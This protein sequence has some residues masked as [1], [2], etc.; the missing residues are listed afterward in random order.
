MDT[1]DPKTLALSLETRLARL[2][3]YCCPQTGAI[4]PPLHASA[5]FARDTAYEKIG[6]RGYAR[7]ENPTYDVLENLLASLDGAAEARVF[8]T[9]MAAVAGLF[10]A[11]RPGDHT[12]VSKTQYFGTPKWLRDWAVPWGLEIDLVDTTDL[13]AVAAAL[14]PGQTKLVY[15]ETPANPTW[16][17]TDIRGC[18]DLAHGIGARLAVDTTAARPVLCQPIAHGA[19]LVVQSAT[20]WLNGHSDVLAGVLSTARTDGFWEEIVRN[21]YL[22]GA[23]LGSFEAWLLTRGLRTLFLRVRH[24]SQSALMIARRL[25]PHPGLAAV[26]YPGLASDPGHEVATRQMTGGF[27]GLLSLRVKGGAEAALEV[28]KR[29]RVFLRATSIGHIESLIEHRATIEGADSDTPPDLLRI[30]VGLE[31]VDDL[32]ADLEQALG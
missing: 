15:I 7:D 1:P 24:S 9:G 29:C 10:Q 32:I 3:G 25:E 11:L 28:A 5:T 13:G 21:R 19:D 18:A 2:D 12:V 30:S 31:A 23:V 6:G 8:A 17:V 20:K 22:A 26:L 27:G 14:R 4:I 16:A